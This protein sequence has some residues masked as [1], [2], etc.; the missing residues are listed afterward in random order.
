M[1]FLL[2]TTSRVTFAIGVFAAAHGSA[3]GHGGASGVVRERMELMKSLGDAMKALGGMITGKAAYNAQTATAAVTVL[4][5]HSGEKLTALFPKGSME[6]PSEARQR[7]WREWPDFERLAKNLETYAGALEIALPSL[8]DASAGNDGMMSGPGTPMGAMMSGTASA[9][10][11]AEM[12]PQGLF[13]MTA[14]TCKSCHT[15]FRE[16]K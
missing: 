13:M 3:Y 6:G 10:E 1:N 5:E 12:P 7:I 2:K 14:Q 4:R 9:A 11:L 8:G 16:K 15:R